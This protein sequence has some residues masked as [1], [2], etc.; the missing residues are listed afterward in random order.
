[1]MSILT[2][3]KVPAVSSAMV[4]AVRRRT[5]T[6]PPFQSRCASEQAE[7]TPVPEKAK[8]GGWLNRAGGFI[9]YAPHFVEV[10]TKEGLRD[11]VENVSRQ[12][13]VIIIFAKR[14]DKLTAR[15]IS[16][17]AVEYPLTECNHK[18][19]YAFCSYTLDTTLPC[20]PVVDVYGQGE[21]LF[22]S[23]GRSP[24]PLRSFLPLHVLDG[25]Y[26]PRADAEEIPPSTSTMLGIPR[27]ELKKSIQAL[28]VLHH[29]EFLE[30]MQTQQERLTK[31]RMGAA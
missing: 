1:M 30:G 18:T 15:L 13:C 24:Y 4:S 10:T 19:V 17:A 25:Q 11:L 16:D 22:R 2:T 5:T 29:T 28:T 23:L 12:Q 3:R 31:I 9:N 14:E 6:Q 26:R 27:A 21:L 8:L 20:F 7:P